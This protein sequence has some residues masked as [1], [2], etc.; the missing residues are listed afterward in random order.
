MHEAELP[1]AFPFSSASFI[2]TTTFESLFFSG[3]SLT[4]FSSDFTCALLLAVLSTLPDFFVS[5]S[6]TDCFFA[7]TCSVFISPLLFASVKVLSRLL[8]V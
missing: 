7:D 1:V 8:Q 6:A 3:V 2:S 4:S 5:S